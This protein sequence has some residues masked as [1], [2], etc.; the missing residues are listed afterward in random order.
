MQLDSVWGE[1]ANPRWL[2][3]RVLHL[4][5]QCHDQHLITLQLLPDLKELDLGLRV[6]D[7]LGKRFFGSMAARRMKGVS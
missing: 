5:T 6:P 7:G 4:D 2:R 1:S 3:P